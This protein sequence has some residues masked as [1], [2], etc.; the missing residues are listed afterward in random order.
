MTAAELKQKY[1]DFF[2]K[3]GHQ[4]L[5]NVSLVPENDPSALFIS[6]GMHPLVP[7]LLGEKHPL[8]KRLVSVQRCLRTDDIDEVGDAVHHTFFEMLGN[9]SLG[10]YFKKEMI[11]WSFE[12]LT[13][14]KYLG[15]PMEKL[16]VTVFAGDSDASFDKESYDLWIEQGISSKRIAKLP[17]K[18]NWW[19]PAGETGP[20]GPDTEM[21]YWTGQEKA[22]AVFA[23]DNPSWVE[24]WND[25]FMEFNK[26]E[27][28]TYDLLQQKNVD[29]G[30]GVDRNLA[31]VNGLDDDY[32]TELFWPLIT[33]IEGL[34]GKKYAANLVDFRIIADH[35]RGAAVLINDGVEPGNKQ[36][37]Y[38]LRRLIRRAAVKMRKI[39]IEPTASVLPV[40]E[41]VT[42]IFKE[43]Y[44]LSEN[45]ER[46]AEVLSK[47]FRA[48]SQTINKGLKILQTAAK[49][50]G[51]TAFDLYQSYGFPLEITLEIV[52]EEN[53]VVDLEKIK[54]EYK[55]EF[56]KHQELSRTASAGMFKGGL[57][58]QSEVAT[59][60]HTATHL[61][62]ASLR[63]VLGKDVRQ[64]GSN[65]TAER[66]RF[67]F[68]YPEKP[69]PEQLKKIEDLV[70]QKIKANL[71]VEMTVMDFEK[72]VA[73][74]ALIVPGEHY[75]V[76]VKVYTIN[77][78]S[79]EVCGGPH[80]RW[81]GEIGSVKIL[82]EEAVG[83]G[84]RRIYIKLAQEWK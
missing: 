22:P 4:I 72:A 68:S 32:K 6:A 74:G 56:K 3:K 19:G 60:Y 67:D 54:K 71:P 62:Q 16:A 46:I 53:K 55:E 58:E 70:N 73:A 23:P 64:S 69:T 66:L 61:L 10:D 7:F 28:G 25:V 24:I 1:F 40:V 41:A 9:W 45:Q 43:G 79:K 52:K 80:V 17:K 50:D 8:G 14:K 65:I 21:F 15:I 75:P 47:E 12:F 39:D 84:K 63:Q 78:F 2:V 37:G 18:N 26:R 38:V 44:S 31:V 82:K 81:T 77:D 36:Q 42:D 29:T 34:S 51:K 76:K 30:L 27:D 33:K 48:F 20:C 11:P 57:T 5:P 59:K 49:T 83:A 13:S 35:L